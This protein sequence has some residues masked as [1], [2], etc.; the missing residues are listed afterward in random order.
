MFVSELEGLDQAQ[1]LI[2]RTTHREVVDGNLPQDAL[3]IDHKQAP[4]KTDQRYD[5]M[6]EHQ[7]YQCWFYYHFFLNTHY[8]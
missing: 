5:A 1:S 4:E 8:Y 7:K 6:Q 3:L 2:H